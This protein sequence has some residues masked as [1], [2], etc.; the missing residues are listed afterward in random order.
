MVKRRLFSRA[1]VWDSS[2]SRSDA[3]RR[4]GPVAC[5]RSASRSKHRS[6]RPGDHRSRSRAR[7]S[8]TTA[9]DR[10]AT[11]HTSRSFHLITMT[12]LPDL[13]STCCCSTIVHST[14]CIDLL[15]GWG[16]DDAFPAA[17]ALTVLGNSVRWTHFRRTSH[18]VAPS[19]LLVSIDTKFY[20]DVLALCSISGHLVVVLLRRTGLDYSFFIFQVFEGWLI[21]TWPIKGQCAFAIT[22]LGLFSFMIYSTYAHPKLI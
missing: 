8:R 10:I 15:G 20:G 13:A 7:I 18:A 6:P 4:S 19:K 22:H 9:S 16:G 1:S 17:D 2:D 11:A 5:M 14:P 12:E 3:P 21:F